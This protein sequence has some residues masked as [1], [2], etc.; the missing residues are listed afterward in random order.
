[1][2]KGDVGG[3]AWHLPSDLNRR[4]ATCLQDISYSLTG[5]LSRPLTFNK[6]KKNMEE[7]HRKKRT[8]FSLYT[9]GVSNLL[10]S[11]VRTTVGERGPCSFPGHRMRTRMLAARSGTDARRHWFQWSCLHQ[12]P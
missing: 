10:H 9:E 8:L 6:R 11:I 3:G 2:R 4:G 12:K 1:M 7:R 5:L